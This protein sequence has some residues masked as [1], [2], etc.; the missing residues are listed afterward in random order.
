MLRVLKDHGARA[1]FHDQ[2]VT[3]FQM[4]KD[5]SYYSESSTKPQ[6]RKDSKWKRVQG[7]EFFSLILLVCQIWGAFEIFWGFWGLLEL[8]DSQFQGYRFDLSPIFLQME[9]KKK[10]KLGQMSS[11]SHK[12]N[13]MV[14]LCHSAYETQNSQGLNLLAFCKEI[15]GVKEGSPSQK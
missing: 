14:R 12:N 9:K 5:S 4:V 15:W 8:W 7:K 2:S 3:G 11:W 6:M 13:S 1:E 10:R